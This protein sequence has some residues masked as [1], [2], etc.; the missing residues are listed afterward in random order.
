VPVAGDL[1]MNHLGLS[2]EHRASLVNECDVIINC[3][4]SVNFDDPLLD[5][6]QINY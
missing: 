2:A 6:I 4:A 3:A 5:A 1:I